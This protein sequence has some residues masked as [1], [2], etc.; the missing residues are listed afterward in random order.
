[1]HTPSPDTS[2][3]APGKRHRSRFVVKPGYQIQFALLLV[4]FQFNVGLV[5]QGIMQ[6]RVREAAEVAGSLRAFL[7][8]NLWNE[9]LPW[10]LG[11]SAAVSV[12]VYLIGLYFSNSIVG[13]LPRLRKALHQMAEGDYSPRLKFR[14]GD[15]LEDLADDVNHLAAIL[16]ERAE[17]GRLPEPLPPRSFEDSESQPAS[18]RS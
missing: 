11:I 13:P 8:M 18:V 15:A 17:S 16:Q 3:V 1:M 12:F 7:A 14:P 5:Y 6:M 10:M 9:V 2:V 4:I